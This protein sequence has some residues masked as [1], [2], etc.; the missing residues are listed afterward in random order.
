MAHAFSP[1][2]QEA[3][4]EAASSSSLVAWSTAQALG[5]T[6]VVKHSPEKLQATEHLSLRGEAEST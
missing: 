5:M 4:A 3:E 6:P 2:T 1:S